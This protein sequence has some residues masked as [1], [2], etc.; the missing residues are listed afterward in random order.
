MNFEHEIAFIKKCAKMIQDITV[1]CWEKFDKIGLHFDFGLFFLYVFFILVFGMSLCWTY[2]IVR[3]RRRSLWIPLVLA[4]V[5]PIIYPFFLLF[6]L[7]TSDE[8]RDQKAG[9]SLDKE[10][11]KRE[12]KRA[13]ELKNNNG[14]LMSKE[15]IPEDKAAAAA[16]IKAATDKVVWNEAY[17]LAM[18]R[19]ENGD[20]IGPWNVTFNDM[21]IKVER[22]LEVQETVL[23]A[24][25]VNEKDEKVKL[26]IPYSK[27]ERW[28]AL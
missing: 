1:N 13:K 25:A 24:T 19:T 2:S 26:R 17:F 28:E 6:M 18:P 5:L 27:I 22:I 12:K 15:Y 4:I 10:E 11:K 7:R 14:D 20:L 9:K 23:V 16:V 21:E 3:A 8:I